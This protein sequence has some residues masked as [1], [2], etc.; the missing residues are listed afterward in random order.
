MYI[1][2]FWSSQRININ[3]DEIIHFIFWNQFFVT[4]IYESYEKMH[5]FNCD[6]SNFNREMEIISSKEKKVISTLYY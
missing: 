1:Y 6:L 5:F 3:N 2:K 4:V